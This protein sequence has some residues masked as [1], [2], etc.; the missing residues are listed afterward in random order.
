MYWYTIKITASSCV[1]EIYVKN[2]TD[3]NT[4]QHICIACFEMINY[5]VKDHQTFI[6]L[7]D[8]K[9]KITET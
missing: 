9:Y 4:A 7:L 5:I 1:Y 6:Y 8:L 2:F 3:I